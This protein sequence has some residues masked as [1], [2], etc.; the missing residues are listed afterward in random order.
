MSGYFDQQIERTG[1]GSVKYD[2]L[3]EYF[4]SSD[5]I[6]MWVADMD[7]KVPECVITALKQ[8]ADH[9]IFG[10][11]VITTGFY[12]SIINWIKKGHD[13]EIKKEWI[14]FSPGI[15]PALT[16]SVMVYTKPGDKVL[17]Q[18]PVYPP[19]FSAIKDNKR[20]LVNNQLVEKEGAYSIDFAELELKLSQDVKMMFFCS[21]HNP[22]GRVWSE[23]EVRHVVSLCRK[24]NVVLISDEIHSDLVYPGHTHI[25]AAIAGEGNDN[26]IICM[27]PSKTF[28]LAGLSSAY[29]LIPDGRLRTKMKRFIGNLHIHYGNIFGLVALQAA[30]E[31]GGDWLAALLRYLQK[32]RD[33]VMNFFGNELPEIKPVSTEGT[34]LVWLDCRKTGMTDNELK[35][36]FIEK[37]G[38]AMNPGPSFGP[39]GEGF[40]R[41]NI[42]C[43]HEKLTEVLYMIKQAWQKH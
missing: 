9:G 35:K 14:L 3:K 18:S 1:T 31:G 33:T 19:F 36:F 21:P 24:Y 22:V 34:Y 28:N 26:M 7:F 16:M 41:L 30:Y 13:W 20:V 15:V 10:Y 43:P 6:P 39:G 12:D 8:R 38:I 29:M 4:G 37:A 40:H 25:P 23:E 11:P 2:G 5:L 42:G 32:N 17:L 27:A